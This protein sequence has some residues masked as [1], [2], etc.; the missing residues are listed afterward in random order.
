[1]KDKVQLIRQEIERRIKNLEFSLENNCVEKHSKLDILGN[2]TTLESLLQ[3]V[4]SIQDCQDVIE[5]PVSEDLKEACDN[6][7]DETWDEH[8]A[9]GMVVDDCYDIWFPSH[10]TDDFF[11]AG[12]KWQ[13]QKDE[14][15]G[16]HDAKKEQPPIDE[17]VIVLTNILNGKELSTPRM[18]CFG[19]IV[20]KNI[21]VDYDGWNIPGVAYWMYYKE[22]K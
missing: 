5:E 8:G 17:E 6:Y 10:A 7:Y 4:D 14:Q 19:H 16:W 2:I 3:F 12:A 21:C 20:D 9:K 22:P 11:K 1:M 18:I 15:L 13:K